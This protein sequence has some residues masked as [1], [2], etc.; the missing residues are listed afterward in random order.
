MAS[1]ELSN[2]HD[3][4]TLVEQLSAQQLEIDA[5]EEQLKALRN[6]L[7]VVQKHSNQFFEQA[8]IGYLILN[9]KAG[10]VKS[11]QTLHEWLE[12]HSTEFERYSYFVHFI[13]SEDL[14]IFNARYQAF[15]RRPENKTIKLRLKKRC[16]ALV[17]VE[18]RGRLLHRETHN[19]EAPYLLVNISDIS[20]YN[21]QEEELR[22]AAKVFENSDQGIMITDARRRIVKVNPAFTV[23]T[24][25]EANDVIGKSPSILKSHRQASQFYQQMWNKLHHDGQWQ[26]EL[27]NQRKNGDLY[28]QWLSINSIVDQYGNATHHIGIFSD[29]T[30]RRE[31]EQQIAV[32]AHYDALT[33]LPNRVLFNERLKNDIIYASRYNRW[34]AVLFLDLDRFKNLN[35]TLGHFMGDLLLQQVAQRL[36][37]CVRES[38]I[39]A[40]FGGDEFVIALPNFENK[41]AAISHTAEIAKRVLAELERAFDL[42]GNT[43]MTSTSIGSAFFPKDGHSVAELIKNAD[44]AMYHAKSQGRNNYQRYTSVMREQALTRSSLENDLR[45][46]L[47]KEELVLYY[48]PIIDLHSSEIVGFEALIRWNHPKLGLLLPKQFIPIAEETGLI[49]GIGE[50]VLNEACSQLKRWHESGKMVKMA[51]NLS[52]RQFVQHD[53]YLMVKNILAF[54]ELSAKYLELEIT[55]ILIMRNVHETTRSLKQLQQLG[56]SISLDDFGTGYSSLTYLKQFPINTLKIDRSFVKDVMATQEDQVIVNSIIAIAQHM[57]LSIITEGIEH[58]DQVT[59]LKEQGC[60]FG[61][62]YLFAAPCLAHDCLF[63]I[64]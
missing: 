12:Y 35:D 3:I 19:Y 25:Y 38:D 63:E 4:A 13:H 27:W 2:P 41:Q 46:A 16:G 9:D 57:N 51:I 62:G 47:K 22:L 37:D 10:I 61:Q 15:F 8:P 53:L 32:M 34:I 44:T 26:G 52:A 18:L 55:E 59:Y 29:I 6:E 43:F 21:P 42:S 20:L 58:L 11:N 49:V 45:W 33:E 1:T 54:Y 14:I 48:Q 36:K 17:L 28:L 24:G 64:Q 60:Q 5:L 40:R 23:I 30:R 31:A 56:V 39:V 7:Q 50:W